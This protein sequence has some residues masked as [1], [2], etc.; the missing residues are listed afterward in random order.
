LE[1][2]GSMLFSLVLQ[3]ITQDYF[4]VVEQNE[5]F[6]ILTFHFYIFKILC[7]SWLCSKNFFKT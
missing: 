7:T 6:V 5:G 2:R 4:W 1:I 3:D